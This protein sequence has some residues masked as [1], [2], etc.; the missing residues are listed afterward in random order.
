[1]HN[2]LGEYR[3]RKLVEDIRSAYNADTSAPRT[4]N[5]HKQLKPVKVPVKKKVRNNNSN[6]NNHNSNG[7]TNNTNNTNSLNINSIMGMF[8]RK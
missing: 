8:L 4:G 6:N 5:K 1:M 3:S 7:N 2:Q